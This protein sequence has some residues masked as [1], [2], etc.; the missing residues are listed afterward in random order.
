MRR[1]ISCYTEKLLREGI[2]VQIYFD[3]STGATQAWH[4]FGV[5]SVPIGPLASIKLH[6]FCYISRSLK[7]Y[8]NLED[9]LSCDSFA[10]IPTGGTCSIIQLLN[11]E[12][13]L[14]VV[15]QDR[16]DWWNGKSLVVQFFPLSFSL[17]LT[18]SVLL[19][20]YLKGICIPSSSL[21]CEGNKKGR[22][23]N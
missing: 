20:D 18:Y 11:F 1:F 23:K 14:S 21:Q 7:I 10:N 17:V 9:F 6:N 13:K 12:S 4:V 19:L 16:N 5:I 15:Q 2:L 22:T 8:F 3:L